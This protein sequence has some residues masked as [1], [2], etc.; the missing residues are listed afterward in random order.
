MLAIDLT[1]DQQVLGV[2]KMSEAYIGVHKA[3]EHVLAT[4]YL[5]DKHTKFDTNLIC[6][7][8]V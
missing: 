2:P 4:S 1:V 7:F 5:I 8:L 6:Y 3:E